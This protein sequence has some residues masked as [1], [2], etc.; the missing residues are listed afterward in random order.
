MN[1]TEFKKL[2]QICTEKVG[3]KYSKR[4]YYYENDEIIIV[5]DTQKSNYDNSYYINYGFWVKAIH[6]NTDYPKI[7]DC[8]IMGRFRDNTTDNFQLQNLDSNKL[9][10]CINSNL[11]DIII[12]VIN[13]GI[14]KYFDLFPRA[15]CMAK[16]KLKTYLEENV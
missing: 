9:M 7:T 3:F 4:N 8:D 12:P 16:L 1:N 2:L 10:E 11:S 6:N 15:I 13:E 14:P 5:I